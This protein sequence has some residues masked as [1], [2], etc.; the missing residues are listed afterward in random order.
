MVYLQHMN[1][2]KGGFGAPHDSTVG[3]PDWVFYIGVLLL[4]VISV[5]VLAA[6]RKSK[7]NGR[8]SAEREAD[9]LKQLVSDKIAKQSRRAKQ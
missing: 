9:A 7:S 3:V 4:V 2:G 1:P 5:G 8:T 6:I